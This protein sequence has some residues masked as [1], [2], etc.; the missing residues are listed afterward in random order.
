MAQHSEIEFPTLPYD[1]GDYTALRAYCLKLPF[2]VIERYY[3]EDSPQRQQGLERY[4]I[5]MREDLIE[6]ACIANPAIAEVLRKART[7]DTITDKALAILIQAAQAKPAP[8]Y[9]HQPIAQ[10]FRARTA[11]CLITQ[12]IKTIEDLKQWITARGHSWWRG[13]PRIGKLRAQAI[14]RWLQKH[15]ATLGEIHPEYLSPPSSTQAVVLLDPTIPDKLAPLT[16]LIL[17]H[18]LS[19]HD[20]IN[21]CR[22]FAL[23]QAK[24]DHEAVQ[25]YLSRYQRH[26]HKAYQKELERLLLWAVMVKQ[27]PL[28]SLMADN[29]ED[30]KQFLAQPSAHFIGHYGS[31]KRTPAWKPF[32]RPLSP[33]SQRQAVQIIRTAFEWLVDVRYLMSNPWKVV[34]D[35]EVAQ[36]IT[37]LQID[38]ALPE[39]LWQKWIAM[40]TQHSA[41]PENKQFRI[42]LAAIL[43]MGDSGLRRVEVTSLTRAQ[44][45][46]SQFGIDSWELKVLGK[47]NKWREV[48]VSTRAIQALE[49]HWEDR[50]KNL[51]DEKHTITPLLCPLVIPKTPSSTKR[52]YVENHYTADSLYRLIKKTVSCL[53][54]DEVFCE[55]ERRILLKVGAHSFRHTFGTQAVAKEV[56]IDVVQK[57]LGHASVATTSLYVKAEKQRM[58]EEVGK[59]FK[60]MAD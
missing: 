26:T 28:S 32:M 15:V 44:L 5:K 4:L 47:R 8:P 38:R 41:L 9:P 30:Y 34:R 59:Y 23:I 60:Q 37:P 17:P 22:Q 24:N 20:G 27:K 36:A 11:Q 1:R 29:C 54:T 33:S 31:R 53:V 7:S 43:L 3:H 57:V 21:R 16:E 56:P 14:I 58:M 18:A 13:I 12:G 6:R 55:N 46:Q 19:G 10:W 51:F 52:H 39:V 45:Q 40:L 50:D 49:A 2:S 25:A 35:P 42:A 48:P